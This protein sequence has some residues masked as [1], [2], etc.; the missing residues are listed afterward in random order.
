VKNDGNERLL[1]GIDA[2]IINCKIIMYG[3]GAG[4]PMY[5]CFGMECLCDTRSERLYDD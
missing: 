2:R 4:I 5:V 1:V 3:F